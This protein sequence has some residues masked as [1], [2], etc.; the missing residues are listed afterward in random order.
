MSFFEK[1]K[2]YLKLG[3]ISGIMFALVMVAFDYFMGRQFS[4]LKFAL[5]FVLFGFFNAYMAYRKV[6]KEE[7]KRNK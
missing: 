4:I 3:V 2:T 6:K 7:A 1:N 5:H